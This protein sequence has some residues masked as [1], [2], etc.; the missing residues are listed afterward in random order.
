MAQSSTTIRWVHQFVQPTE[1]L[2]I[3]GYESGG[4]GEM[5]RLRF[6]IQNVSDKPIYAFAYNIDLSALE[7]M[8]S[9]SM[10]YGG[11]ELNGPHVPSLG[12]PF[13]TP[14]EI[15][16][17]TVPEHYAAVIRDYEQ[18][19]DGTRDVLVSLRCVNFGDGNQWLTGGYEP[20]YESIAAIEAAPPLGPPPN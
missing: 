2:R 18:H 17:L 5:Q 12:S 13:R 1:P 19:A 4:L 9:V 14:G 3:L 8:T 16:T 15:M 11:I 6:R 20:I 7:P 10:L